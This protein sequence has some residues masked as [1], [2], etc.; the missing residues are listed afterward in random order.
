MKRNLKIA[1]I[2]IFS[3]LFLIS[4]NV[5]ALSLR[6]YT[7]NFK[8]TEG[9][10]ERVQVYNADFTNSPAEPMK[11]TSGQGSRGTSRQRL[12]G[13]K[14]KMK[15]PR[16]YAIPTSSVVRGGKD[17]DL[18]GADYELY[19][20][21]LDKNKNYTLTTNCD[22]DIRTIELSGSI[23][24]IY[25]TFSSPASCTISVAQG[26]NSASIQFF[27]ASPSLYPYYICA[28]QDPNDESSCTTTL[29]ISP[30]STTTLYV[31]FD[32]GFCPSESSPPCPGPN[33]PC[34]G[35]N[36]CTEPQCLPSKAE[37]KGPSSGSTSLFQ[38]I[39]RFLKAAIR[40][41]AS[42]NIT[43][44]IITPSMVQSGWV[45]IPNVLIPGSGNYYLVSGGTPVSNQVSNQITVNTVQYVCKCYMGFGYWCPVT[46]NPPNGTGCMRSS[47]CDAKCQFQIRE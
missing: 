26:N 29:T 43:D 31:Y 10:R 25:G 23:N 33:S 12:R 13:G 11:G 7:T 4:S 36:D 22:G 41:G 16:E 5:Y 14:E 3:L 6:L 38:R 42:Q 45:I 1:I 47:A 27:I 20:D 46:S 28:L 8:E 44:I 24:P 17:G 34:Q 39:L 32:K 21:G 37:M 35:Q 40:G 15:I 30:N 19:I 2:S 18:K 9:T